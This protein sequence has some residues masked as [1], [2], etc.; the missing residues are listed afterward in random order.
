M[1]TERDQTTVYV[2]QLTSFQSKMNFHFIVKQ[3]SSTVCHTY[4][5]FKKLDTNKILTESLSR[6]LLKHD[7][8]IHRKS[9]IYQHLSRFFIVKMILKKKVINTRLRKVAMPYDMPQA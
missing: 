1:F 9:G 7:T 6:K 8:L 5:K 2:S 4:H 3:Y